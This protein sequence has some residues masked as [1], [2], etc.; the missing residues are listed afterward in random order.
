MSKIH[1]ENEAQRKRIEAI[2]KKQDLFLAQSRVKIKARTWQK[3]E[4]N[5]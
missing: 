5:V 3:K 2:L 4:Q 1:Y